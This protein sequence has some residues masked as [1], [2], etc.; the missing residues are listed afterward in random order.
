MMFKARVR[1]DVIRR[2]SSKSEVIETMMDDETYRNC[3]SSVGKKI[4]EQAWCNS[5]FPGADELRIYNAVK[6]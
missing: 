3:N 1:L 5:M 2:G 4:V 6:I